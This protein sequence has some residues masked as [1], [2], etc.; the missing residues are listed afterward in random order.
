MSKLFV[1]LREGEG[2][3]ESRRSINYDPV[4]KKKKKKK[5]ST[6]TNIN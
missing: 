4:K 1:R 5:K 6:C 2:H 3:S